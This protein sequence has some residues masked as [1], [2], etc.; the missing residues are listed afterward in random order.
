[1]KLPSDCFGNDTN[2]T[3][4]EVGHC[5]PKLCP[6]RNKS[7]EQ[8]T[9]TDDSQNCCSV[10]DFKIYDIPCKGFKLPVMKVLACGCAMCQTRNIKI[11]GTV[12]I[13]PSK[14]LAKYFEVY[15]NGDFKTYTNSKGSF[16]IFVS[17]KVRK[18]V[19][20]VQNQS[21][22]T[23]TKFIDLPETSAGTVYTTIYVVDVIK[24]VQIDPSKEHVIH[25]GK[26]SNE[27]DG[28]IAELH[29][30]KNSFPNSLFEMQTGS[31]DLYISILDAKTI[32]DIDVMPG[33]LRYVNEDGE[34]NPIE[35]FGSFHIT[36]FDANTRKVVSVIKNITVLPQ[37]ELFDTKEWSLY[38][39]NTA[40]GAYELL[41]ITDDTF[42]FIDSIRLNSWLTIGRSI[43]VYSTCFFKTHVF[44]HSTFTIE[45]VDNRYQFYLQTVHISTGFSKTLSNTMS[46]SSSCFETICD[47]T[48]GYI[49]MWV[50]NIETH[51]E[52]F[53]HPANP[54]FVDDTGLDEQKQALLQYAVSSDNTHLE[55][56][57]KNTKDGPF[58]DSESAC[59]ASDT[60]HFKFFFSGFDD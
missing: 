7:I 55:I 30:Q 16:N 48:K 1:M 52:E 54:K 36:A 59:L 51:S 34:L 53:L 2:S 5:N 13:Y 24:T 3:V 18:L 21:G 56:L 39:L 22:R 44:K 6:T 26:L 42:G 38:K 29:L 45:I 14:G 43:S 10:S 25:I 60:N 8:S 9:C 33:R 31:V 4:Q 20:S 23:T 47:N 19:L 40:F 15:L 57:F 41:P 32:A 35:S 49:E 17:K 58:F 46:P 50:S 11:I 37:T 12:F 27:S 28:S